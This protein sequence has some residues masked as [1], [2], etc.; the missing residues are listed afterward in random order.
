M[1]RHGLQILILVLLAS[2]LTGNAI[3]K[4]EEKE[5]QPTRY[6]P[7][8]PP[9]VVNV[10]DGSSSRFLQVTAQVSVNTPKAEEHLQTHMGPIRHEMIMLLS[11][12]Q[13]ADISTLKGKENLRKKSLSAI[14]SVLK[15]NTGKPVVNAV[16]FTGFIIQ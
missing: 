6:I 11:G 3:G 5:K 8:D 7:L 10:E 12:Q 9:I 15:K 14:Q 1:I 4:E 13:V 16:F 2:S